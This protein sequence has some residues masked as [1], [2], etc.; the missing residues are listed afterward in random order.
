MVVAEN[1]ALQ[2][3]RKSGTWEDTESKKEQVAPISAK[4]VGRV[5]THMKGD[6]D[7]PLNINI[8]VRNQE[9]N[10]NYTQCGMCA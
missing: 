6:I 8:L 9:E 10:L 1:R 4:C 7:P 3:R 2:Q 5:T